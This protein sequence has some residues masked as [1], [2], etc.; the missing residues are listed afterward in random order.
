MMNNM[1]SRII[2]LIKLQRSRKKTEFI[3]RPKKRP[4]ERDFKEIVIHGEI[5]TGL[6]AELR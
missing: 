4:E 6:R 5:S 3:K 2:L 1:I